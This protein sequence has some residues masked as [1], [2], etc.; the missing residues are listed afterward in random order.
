MRGRREIRALAAVCLVA[1]GCESEPP[2]GTRLGDLEPPAAVA[3][4][5][6]LKASTDRTDLN[7]NGADIAKIQV[8]VTDGAGRPATGVRVFFAATPRGFSDSA[9]TFTAASA[10]VDAKGVALGVLLA[11]LLSYV[12]MEAMIVVTATVADPSLA[13]PPSATLT[14]LL[15]PKGTPP[16][17]TTPP[18]PV[19]P[20]VP[21]ITEL[22]PSQAPVD[23]ATVIIVLGKNFA[24]GADVTVV[25]TLINPPLT[26]VPF[27]ATTERLA[28]RTPVLPVAKSGPAEL[29][30]TNPDGKISNHTTLTFTS[31]ALGP[32]VIT[33]IT[34]AAPVPICP[35][36]AAC[37]TA[38]LV[39]ECVYE[40]YQLL[41]VGSNF[42]PCASLVLVHN[43][44]IHEILPDADGRHQAN[45][46]PGGGIACPLGVGVPAA[47]SAARPDLVPYPHDLIVNAGG[48]G[49]VPYSA[50]GS[51]YTWIDPAQIRFLFGPQERVA[52]GASDSA[53]L[54]VSNSPG[55]GLSGDQLSAPR[56]VTFVCGKP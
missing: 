26:L 2:I 21:E 31:S 50:A 29:F 37:T 39:S 19:E 34:P 27:E 38:C 14:I 12:P 7:A 8:K 36:T 51:A 13:F 17:P 49:C 45:A 43:G 42:S 33:A 15:A 53:Q 5:L 35:V 18:A 23:S 48:G 40:G 6:T 46:G 47:C 24:T 20:I 22:L 4:A 54:Y 16:D 30:V 56:E 3:Q 9:G 32:P 55:S 52:C 1:L 44:V 10:S 25:S 41:V 28:V 11:P